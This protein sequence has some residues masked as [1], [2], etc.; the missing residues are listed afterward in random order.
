MLK[1]LSF[2]QP[3]GT[4]TVKVSPLIAG[5]AAAGASVGV[6]SLGEDVDEPDASLPGS[7]PSSWQ[8]LSARHAT[9]AATVP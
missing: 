4:F 8:P 3:S 5:P 7:L 1:A 2:V 9:T 6:F